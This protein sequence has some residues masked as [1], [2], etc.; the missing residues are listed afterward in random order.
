MNQKLT[1][2]EKFLKSFF[3]ISEEKTRSLHKMQ[4]ALLG[5]LIAEMLKILSYRQREVIKLRYGLVDGKFYTRAEIERKF[6]MKN[7]RVRRIEKSAITLLKVYYEIFVML[8]E[9]L[10]S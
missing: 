1:P 8:Q 2:Q 6:E 10:D 4:Q 5:D 9:I 3:G 7:G